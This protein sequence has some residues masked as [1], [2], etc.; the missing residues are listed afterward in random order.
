MNASPIVHSS[1]QP[2][3]GYQ[4][5]DRTPRLAFIDYIFGTAMFSD[6]RYGVRPRRYGSRTAQANPALG[7]QLCPLRLEGVSLRASGRRRVLLGAAGLV[8]G[9]ALGTRAARADNDEV[10][11]AILSG[12]PAGLTAGRA[13]VADRKKVLVLQERDRI[14]GRAL[15]DTSLGFGDRPRRRVAGAGSFGQGTWRE[16]AARDPTS[17]RSC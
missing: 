3:P 8:P 14:G 17:A 5:P 12:G 10:N 13:L 7:G 16:V 1:W 15:T 11:I 9:L 6:R 2:S 4:P